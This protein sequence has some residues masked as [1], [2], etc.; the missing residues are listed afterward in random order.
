MKEAERKLNSKGYYLT[1]QYNGFSTDANEYELYKDDE[2]VMDH[3]TE[4]QVIS[5]SN[6]L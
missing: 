2:C 3:L 4:A 1:N 6:I 5:L